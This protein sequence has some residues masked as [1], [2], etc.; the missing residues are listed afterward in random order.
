MGDI[1][2]EVLENINQNKDDQKKFISSMKEKVISMC[3]K[4][5]IYNEAF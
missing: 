2:S 1:I 3:K 5:P 4:Y